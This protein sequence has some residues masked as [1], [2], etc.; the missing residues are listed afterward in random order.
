MIWKTKDCPLSRWKDFFFACRIAVRTRTCL[1]TAEFILPLL[2]LDRIC[3]GSVE[4]F[5]SICQEFLQI[6][7]IDSESARMDSSERQ[8]AVGEFFSM[9]DTLE[10][11]A[12]IEAEQRY[13]SKKS[14]NLQRST[15]GN[16]KNSSRIKNDNSLSNWPSDD[17]IT[18][19]EELISRI[20]LVD[21]ARAAT[22]VGMNAKGLRL[23]ELVARKN[24]VNDFFES[25]SEDKADE[26]SISGNIFQQSLLKNA[27]IDLMKIVL[28]NLNDC[29]TLNVLGETSYLV[30]PL[31][32]VTDSIQWKEASGDYEGALRDYDR[33]IQARTIDHP[34]AE[35]G[36]EK[37]ALGC[38]LKLGRFQSV[39]SRTVTEDKH[40]DKTSTRAFAVE[41]ATHLG[42]WD[43][44]S[45]L[46]T[47]NERKKM[48]F[49]PDDT[50]RQATGK[51]IVCLRD[52][53]W[54]AVGESLRTA[55]NAVMDSLSSVARE[56]Y[57]RS[58]TD[59]AKLQCIRELEDAAALFCTRDDGDMHSLSEIAESTLQK[60]WAW[61]GRLGLTT[62]RA[63]SSI[64][65]TRVAISRLDNDSVME[66]SLLLDIGKQ[67]FNNGMRTVAENFYSQA[68][69]ALSSIPVCRN[70][71]NQK[72]DSLLDD[73]RFQYANLKKESGE[74]LIALKII[75]QEMVQEALIEMTRNNEDVDFLKKIAVKYEQAR[76]ER[77]LGKMVSTGNDRRLIDRFAN[78]LLR[79]TQW[80]VEAGMQSGNEIMERFQTVI[81]LSPEW[82]K[83]ESNCVVSF[84][85]SYCF[86][87]NFHL[88]FYLDLRQGHFQFAKYLNDL[89]TRFFE[90]D[91]PH[92][93]EEDLV[94][95]H[96]LYRDRVC[97]KYILLAIEHYAT[98]LRRDMKQVYHALP[99][100]LSL[101]F[102]FVSLRP[103]SSDDYMPSGA[104]KPEYLSKFDVD[105]LQ[106]CQNAQTFSFTYPVQF[107]NWS[108]FL[109]ENQNS[110][111]LLMADN[112][113]AIPAAAYYTAVPQ[114]ISRVIH[115]NED[116]AKVVKRILERVLTKFPPQ[117][118]WHLAWLKGS[119]NKERSKIGTDIFKGA[120][121]VL[122]KN[123]QPQVANLLKASDSLFKFLQDLAR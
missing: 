5:E 85:L 69:A 11:W 39:L 123:R 10:Y 55:R 2:V 113:K 20:P 49:G 13:R 57:S 121:R 75:G 4:E 14:P 78:R 83:G 50:Y 97:H 28:S 16:A 84:I 91:S 24:I 89:V 54:E 92:G 29:E 103:P 80:T 66:S 18:Q 17:T 107:D 38:L 51:A 34:F 23:L 115:N 110:A 68:E 93:M 112:T 44:L 26:I 82:E 106:A 102:D 46:V 105:Y 100:L 31:L 119:K 67:A 41:A 104:S 47:E 45:E 61:Q 60:G 53:R 64:M 42:H 71:R 40:I 22:K 65:N 30:N 48:N 74:N 36:I 87:L 108:D 109:A 96:A 63:A 95:F 116:T 122:I 79:L 9:I 19:I 72:L 35:S 90:K 98:T 76:V 117:A 118:M 111:N 25:S 99:R 3:F 56:S 33:A 21:Q 77:T 1:E 52:Q 6:L 94:R 120:Q 32:Q 43:R 27:N 59:I 86:T 81:K 58:Y 101:W 37:G 73:V 62:P 70:D 12:E 7:D 114:L 88:S 15:S 8:K